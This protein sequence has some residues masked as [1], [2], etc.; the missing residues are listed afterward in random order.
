MST[1][2]TSTSE[3]RHGQRRRGPATN[4]SALKEWAEVHRRSPGIDATVPAGDL[5][6]TK[7]KQRMALLEK[8]LASL[9]KNQAKADMWMSPHSFYEDGMDEILFIM[10]GEL[11]PGSAAS[12]SDHR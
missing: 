9:H 1:E 12:S 10:K 6:N 2:W 11:L 7:P 4:E 3:S 5:G 8:Q